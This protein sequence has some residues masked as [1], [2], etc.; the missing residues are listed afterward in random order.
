MA[1][2]GIIIPVY[3]VKVY[4]QKCIKSIL[5]Q[6]FQDFEIIL[7]D[8]GSTD[9]SEKI[10]DEYA[11]SYKNIKVI[12]KKNEGVWSARNKG[13][14]ENR[15]AMIAHI[16]PDDWIDKYYLETLYRLMKEKKADLVI[17]CGINVLEGQKICKG[18]QEREKSFLKAEEISKSE[19]Y[20]RMFVCENNASVVC[21]AKLYRK[22]LFDEIR[23]PLVKMSGDSGTID[24][25]IEKCNKIVYTPYA[26]YYY[27]RR[28]GSLVHGRMSDERW[29]AVENARNLWDFI[30]RHYPDIEDAAKVFY[31]NNC[32]QIMNL[33]VL[34]PGKRYKKECRMIRNEVLREGTFFVF[35]RYTKL[36]EKSAVICL[37][38]GIPG[39]RLAWRLYLWLTKK[40]LGTMNMKEGH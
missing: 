32:I 38:F 10:C 3:N 11:E 18:S 12:H 20:R 31:L 27:L 26:G 15:C 29:I 28:K 21:W 19:A 16:D 36:E 37:L 40:G 1:E 7:V 8:D 35:N 23:Y 39:Y 30:K 33:M 24:R 22:E 5:G 4:L 9:G 17:S 25:I 2:I 14:E 13:L 6:T 34:D